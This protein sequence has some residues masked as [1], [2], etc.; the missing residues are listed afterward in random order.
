M[1]NRARENAKAY[2]N[3]LTDELAYLHALYMSSKNDFTVYRDH[4]EPGA[5]QAF[6]QSMEAYRA[7]RMP[8]SDLLETQETLVKARIKLLETVRDL[9]LAYVRL[10]RLVGLIT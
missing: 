10:C 8:L 1:A 5:T 2:T 6:S 4:I 3:H 7:G 9:N